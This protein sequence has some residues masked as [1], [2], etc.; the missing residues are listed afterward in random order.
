MVFSSSPSKLPLLTAV[1]LLTVGCQ[2]SE[3]IGTKALT[4]NEQ[5]LNDITTFA[6]RLCDSVS[7]TGGS[8]S[9]SAS[10]KA[11][12]EVKGLVKK[13]ADLGFH[14]A[15]DVEAKHYEGLLQ[16]DLAAFVA[17]DARC[18]ENIFNTL[19]AKLLRSSPPDALHSDSPTVENSAKTG[20]NA[21]VL[22]GVSSGRDI[23]IRH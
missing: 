23:S 2:K 17:S 1:L 19:E 18:R 7:Q 6:R 22:Q 4:P 11:S 20:D 9:A 13:L 16:S 3:P 14:G 15:V 5:A 8:E 10:A 21:V 12:G